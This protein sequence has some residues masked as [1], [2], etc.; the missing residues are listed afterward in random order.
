[1]NCPLC[2]HEIETPNGTTINSVPTEDQVV[3]TVRDDSAN[4]PLKIVP[5]DEVRPWR[6][7]IPRS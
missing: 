7:G 6:T 3:V 4:E 5:I 1:M 2:G